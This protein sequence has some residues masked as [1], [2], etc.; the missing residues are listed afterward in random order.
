MSTKV[1]CTLN[2]HAKVVRFRTRKEANGLQATLTLPSSKDFK[3]VS[4]FIN[5]YLAFGN[6]EVGI[7]TKPKNDGANPNEKWHWFVNGDKAHGEGVWDA[8]WNIND[9]ER[10][11]IKAW[12]DA[13]GR[14]NFQVKDKV[15]FTS[16]KRFTEMAKDA[17][18]VTAAAQADFNT[19]WVYTHNQ[20][21]IEDFMYR[22]ANNRWNAVNSD[23]GNGYIE[24]M[25]CP[26]GSDDK[27]YTFTEFTATGKYLYSSLK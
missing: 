27:S 25:N 23:A 2:E 26:E 8:P 7:S 3:G 9:G 11:L 16:N 10:V 15:V 12:Y 14:F 6:W 19:P 17:R 1:K 21:V 18:L 24:V 20:V 13:Q 22:D 4:G 5:F